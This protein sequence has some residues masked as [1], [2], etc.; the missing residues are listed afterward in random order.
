VEGELVRHRDRREAF[1][2]ASLPALREAYD[3]C[4]AFAEATRDARLDEHL[5]DFWRE[6]LA[7][8]A[9]YPSFNEMQVM[10]RGFTYPIADR[11]KAEDLQ[12]ETAYARA[13][14]DVV[15]RSVPASYFDRFQESAVGCPT[16]FVF[17]G[18]VL[19]AG[20][21][22]NALTAYRIVSACE[23]LGL[24][25]RPLR[26]LEIGAG[27]GQVAHQLL[28]QLDVQTYA[29]CDLP[30]NA[31]LTGF[32]LRANHPEREA[33]FI[34][35]GDPP[36]NGAPGLVFT[37]PPFLER[38]EGE[39]DLIVNSYSFQEMTLGS[40]QE[41]LAFAAERLTAGGFLY[42][43]NSHA[44]AGVRRP[45][46][47]GIEAFELDTLACPRRFPWQPNGT[48]PYELVLRARTAPP[49]TGERLERR[50]AQ[51]DG[52]GGAMQ[53]GLSEELEPLIATFTGADE[54]ASDDALDALAAAFAGPI[55]ERREAARHVPGAVGAHIAGVLAFVAGDDA[56]AAE[57][58][59]EALKGLGETHA[60]VW[61]LTVLAGIDAARGE[62]RR[63]TQRA[64]EA[65]GLAPHLARDVASLTGTPDVARAMLASLARPGHVPGATG[66]L[67]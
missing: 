52:L 14:W 48:V 54:G 1:V 7:E 31:F 59:D 24:M 29:V 16:A 11:G 9:N 26:I 12:A 58:L 5:S 67:A 21:I 20:G 38:L 8:R 15:G 13:A 40:V 19:S 39:F 55:A 44:K 50:R 35:P 23:R 2:S 64:A 33:R 65:A 25:G 37:I 51:L 4:V 57:T 62:H 45:S 46:D 43:L 27:Y 66:H 30:E 60:R 47:Y 36:A 18:H 6:I 41:Y 63:S 22:V 3:R 56:H 61:A 49:L 34:G 28:Q 17:D 10:R 53:L 42:S 32:Y